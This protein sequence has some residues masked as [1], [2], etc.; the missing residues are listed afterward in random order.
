M[1][2][3]REGEQ[4]HNA[5]LL[6]RVRDPPSLNR[7]EKNLGGAGTILSVASQFGS[8]LSPLPQLT[9]DVGRGC[10]DASRALLFVSR[11]YAARKRRSDWHR[12][13]EICFRKQ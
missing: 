13:G 7:V 3:R 2:C 1:I 6:C 11:Q 12:C 9:G 8:R 5:A 10:G 4:V